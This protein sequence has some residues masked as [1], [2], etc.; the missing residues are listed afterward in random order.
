MLIKIFL[1]ANNSICNKM[2]YFTYW[3]KSYKYKISCKDI[4]YFEND[5]RIIKWL[6]VEI[7]LL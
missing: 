6:E 3:Y 1:D 4:L 2:F 7:K 5:G